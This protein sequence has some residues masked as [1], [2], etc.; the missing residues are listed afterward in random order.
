VTTVTQL[1]NPANVAPEFLSMAQRPD[2]R[3]VASIKTLIALCNYLSADDLKRIREAYRLSDQAHLG[4]LRTSGE[5]YISHPIAVAE[6]CARW[7][8]DADA[9]MAA[10]L[11]DVVE[12]CDV[13]VNSLIQQFGPAVAALVDGLSKLDRAEFASREVAQ[14]ENFRKMLLAMSRDVRV[15]LIKLA[16][17]LHNLQTLDA[18]QPSKRRRVASETLSI[19]APIAD[20]L[21]LH[22]LYR[23][24]V[25]RS[26]SHQSPHRF[27]VLEKAVHAQKRSSRKLFAKILSGVERELSK[28]GIE[29]QIQS[30]EKTIY[31]IYRK[32]RSK[33]Q[34]FSSVMDVYAFR[35][36]VDS[37]SQCYIAL[38]AVHSAFRPI[39]ERFKDYIANQK[40]NG[41]QSLHTTVI[42]PHSMPVEF[43]IRTREMHRTAEAGVAS[44]WLYKAKNESFSDLQTR[45]H[46]W[47]QGLLDIQN[48]THDS[49]EFLENVKVDLFPDAIYVF[50]PK[51]LIRALPKHAT[52]LDFA[53]SIHTDIGQRAYAAKINGQ[54]TPLRTE[55]SHGDVVEVITNLDSQPS[56]SWLSFVRTGKARAEIRHYLRTTQLAESIQFGRQLLEQALASIRIDAAHIDTNVLERAVQ[57][58]GAQNADDLYAEIGLGKIL[59]QIVARAIARQINPDADKLAESMRA[60]PVV[61]RGSE[62]MTVQC[63]KCCFP[64]PGDNIIGFMKGGHGLTLHRQG[65]AVADRQRDKDADRQVNAAWARDVS[66]LFQCK[67][68]A[69]VDNE[70]GLLSRVTGEIAGADSNIIDLQIDQETHGSATLRFLVE[71]KNRQHIA[72]L[73]RILRR[74]SGVR[75]IQ[76]A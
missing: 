30:R 45:T 74:A 2:P 27:A 46:Q 55:L 50:T 9:I 18:V 6:I 13:S 72:R 70:S 60:L 15:I 17:R 69:F 36:V 19:Y 41:Y 67:I 68:E 40:T 26:F 44:H 64:V 54:E 48:N 49:L 56:A 11:H 66:G 31:G 10:L 5:P 12:D 33:R 34:P 8:L 37:V 61:I 52:V 39:S 47:L 62:G 76:R 29:A 32:M 42:G 25:D 20:R 63:A 22:E 1:S 7:G 28:V 58:A 53:Y 4:Q 51:G 35:L 3:R 16:D 71:V 21:G 75:S 24:L 57:D 59:P 65:C 73:L 38:G 23:E 14:A 43:Q